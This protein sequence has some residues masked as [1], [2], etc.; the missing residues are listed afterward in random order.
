MLDPRIQAMLTPYLPKAAD[1]LPAIYKGS[2]KKWF[3]ATG[4]MAA[5]CVNTERLKAKNPPMQTSWKDLTNPVYKG[6]LVMPNPPAS[7]TEIGRASCGARGRQ[8]V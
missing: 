4:Y 8:Y 3:A 5:F 2:D 1:K 6:E 7:R